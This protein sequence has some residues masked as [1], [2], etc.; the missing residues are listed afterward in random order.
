MFVEFFKKTLTNQLFIICRL[1]NILSQFCAIK[2]HFAT[3]NEDDNVTKFPVV[4]F[5]K[6]SQF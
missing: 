3:P 5:F 6:K 2:S 1:T 4:Q